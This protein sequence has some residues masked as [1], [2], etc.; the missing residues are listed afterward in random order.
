MCGKLAVL[1]QKYVLTG[2]GVQIL[3]LKGNQVTRMR[4]IWT[5]IPVKYSSSDAG[6]AAVHLM[7]VLQRYTTW[8]ER[9][10]HVS[11][12]QQGIWHA[13]RIYIQL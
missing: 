11:F 3:T 1:V 9:P 13:I 10:S 5:I 8:N 2:T 12:L 6:V 7:Q 4:A